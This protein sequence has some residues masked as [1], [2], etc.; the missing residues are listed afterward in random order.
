MASGAEASHGQF[1]SRS[2]QMGGS[3]PTFRPS[4]HVFTIPVEFGILWGDIQ[5]SPLFLR[6]C[7][8]NTVYRHIIYGHYK[9]ESRVTG[10]KSNSLHRVSENI[11]PLWWTP[12]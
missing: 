9:R 11:A 2:V 4:L 7:F 10:G 5:T 12:W 8:F 6:V 1:I 3:E